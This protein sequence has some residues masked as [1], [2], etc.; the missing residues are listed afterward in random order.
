MKILVNSRLAN[1]LHRLTTGLAYNDE[2]IYYPPPD[3]DGPFDSH[4]QPTRSTSFFPVACSF[5]DKPDIESWKDFIDVAG[6]TAEIRLDELI[7]QKGGTF[8]L[9]KHFGD[10]EYEDTLFE[11]IGVQN[12]G[13]FGSIA[14]LK[15]VVL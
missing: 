8:L 4:G 12:R 15:K 13:T 2:A 10:Y 11:I 7:P 6:I 3:P 5:T 14:A 9:V 1:Q